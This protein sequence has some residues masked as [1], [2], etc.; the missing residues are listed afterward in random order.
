MTGPANVKLT[1]RGQKALRAGLD[2]LS[3]GA[4]LL[5]EIMARVKYAPLDNVADLADQLIERYG[6]I[7]NAIVAIKSGIVGFEPDELAS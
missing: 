4:T 7:E 2:G 6:S 1:R 3:L 5:M